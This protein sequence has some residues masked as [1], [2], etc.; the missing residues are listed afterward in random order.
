MLAAGSAKA[1]WTRE[2]SCR[3]EPAVGSSVGVAPA[4]VV[5][6]ASGSEISEMIAGKHTSL[7]SLFRRDLAAKRTSVSAIST[8]AAVLVI[9]PLATNRTNYFWPAYVSL[10][11]FIIAVLFSVL[12]LRSAKSGGWLSPE[13]A[14]VAFTSGFLS[15]IG[16]VLIG[17]FLFYVYAWTSH[18][19][20]P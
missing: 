18:P 9:L 15:L 8:V 3:V 2:L 13:L 4:V 20:F 16:I 7:L 11:I 17:V 19:P 12:A 5:T 6:N 10:A 14:V 1:L